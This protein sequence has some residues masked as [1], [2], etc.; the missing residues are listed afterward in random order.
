MNARAPGGRPTTGG[1]IARGRL[2]ESVS[3]AAT[4]AVWIHGPVGFGKSTLAAQI[5]GSPDRPH[6]WHLVDACDASLGALLDRLGLALQVR[7]LIPLQSLPA[8]ARLLAGSPEY[9]VR[10]FWRTVARHLPQGSAIVFDE[11]EN[12][13]VDAP[14]QIAFVVACQ[15][16]M[17]TT[18]VIF[19]SRNE[20]PARFARLC[21]NGRLETIGPEQLRFDAEDVRALLA[22]RSD[23][24]DEASVEALLDMTEGWPAAASLLV[25]SGFDSSRKAGLPMRLART[26]RNYLSAEVLHH[27]PER[28]RVDLAKLTVTESVSKELALHLTGS[29]LVLK[30]LD[31]MSEQGFFVE[32]SES[33]PPRY[34]LHPLLR[35]ALSETLTKSLEE[36]EYLALLVRAGRA[37]LQQRE[38][39]AGIDLLSQA[40]ASADIADAVESI[41]P[42][43]FETGQLSTLKSLLVRVPEE[44][45]QTRPWLMYWDAMTLVNEDPRRAKSLMSAAYSAFES[46]VDAIGRT[47]TW[48]GSIDSICAE[49]AALGELDVWLDDYDQQI[50]P[51]VALLPPAVGARVAA[52]RFAALAFRRPTSGDL[53]VAQS[54]VRRFIET[55]TTPP[56]LIHNARSM[57]FIHA[58]WAGEVADAASHL[59]AIEECAKSPAS[60]PISRLFAQV[61]ALALNL[62]RGE[63]AACERLATACLDFSKESGIHIWDPI[64]WGHWVCA[65]VGQGHLAE[66]DQLLPR[67]RAS[68]SHDPRHQMSRYLGISA[69]LAAA[70]G[71]KSVSL[72]LCDEALASA[73]RGGAPNFQAFTALKVAASLIEVDSEDRRADELL[74]QVQDFGR[75]ANPMLSWL[76]LL[77][78]AALT[79][80]RGD[81]QLARSYAEQAFAIGATHGYVHAGFWPRSLIQTACEVAVRHRIEPDYSA[82][83]IHQNLFTPSAP[84]Y[85]LEDWPWRVK[86]RTL[87]RFTVVVDGHPLAFAGKAQRAP[88]RL[89]QALVAL[90]GRDVSEAKM[91]DFLWPDVEA[92]DAVSALGVTLHRLR[93]L[94]I[95]GCITRQGGR[96]GL[97]GRVVWVDAWAFERALADLDNATR[98]RAGEIR[99]LYQGVFLQDVDNAPWALP[100]R[101]R[102]RDRLIR[103][104]SNEARRLFVA[105][106]LEEAEELV[107]TGLEVDDLVEDFYRSLMLIRMERGDFGEALSA[108][109]R[110]EQ[111][112]EARLS[113]RPSSATQELLRSIH[114]NELHNNSR[115]GLKGRPPRNGLGSSLK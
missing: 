100:M 38:W 9:S 55:G 101:E 20:P 30:Q 13:A 47:L 92:D 96:L 77:V 66:A 41:G 99:S 91:C 68:L 19:T 106:R 63:F 44:M 83:L 15:E 61:G 32:R 102:L 62:F 81:G 97:D 22:S 51:L 8:T 42:Q 36:A 17:P 76:A 56:A 35:D 64:I 5:I 103:Y 74:R 11:M 110:C 7:Q 78:D 48:A 49:Y 1:A 86:I 104:I 4:A 109:R 70:R 25:K 6:L 90:G 46:P 45:R 79:E 14:V 21:V 53:L 10:H 82:R 57:L 88:I 18:T 26:L 80:Q 39:I 85:R 93:S 3:S 87:G 108:Y 27:L 84:S 89:L 67:W 65:V 69:Y 94:L 29:T 23:S 105:Q 2:V 75:R 24:V 34:R 98:L 115:D 58:L 107:L 73:E 71:E 28:V 114:A 33:A 60:A 95:D 111:V 113:V 43:L 59:F 31:L 54:Q 50:S 12:L 40:H 72:K 16:L 52:S 37:L 112:L